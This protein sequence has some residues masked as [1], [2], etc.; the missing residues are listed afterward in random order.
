MA[1]R[2]LTEEEF[3][4][5]SDKDKL[6]Y[7][8]LVRRI[9]GKEELF[10]LAHDVLGYDKI[11]EAVHGK[12]IGLLTK[13]KSR[14]KLFLLPRGS[15][16]SSIAT[17]SYIIWRLLNN[18]NLR[19]LLDSEVLGNSEK[20][21]EQIKTHFRRE[22][23]VNLYG[24][25]IS[26]DKRE[27]SREFTVTNR[28]DHTKKEPSVY[29]A[30]VGTVNVGPH[31]DLII[32]DDLHSEKNVAT[33]DQ[34]HKVINHYRLLLSLLEPEGELIVIG[35][36]WHFLDL[37]SKLIEEEVTRPDTEWIY[38]IEKAI[39]DDGSMF[40]PSRITKEFLEEQRRSQGA[41]LFSCLYQNEPQSGDTQVFRKEDF[42]YW[43]GDDF[44]MQD[45]KR[46][47]LSICIMVD[48]AFSSKES[49]DFTGIVA[50][51]ISASGTIY[52]LDAIRR[53][54]GLQEVF[55]DIIRLGAKFGW[56]RIRTVGIET[57]N[58][59]ELERFFQEQMRKTNRFFNIERLVPDS[60]QSKKDRIEKA[61]QAR[62]SNHSV[63]IKKGM[64][65][66]ED[67]LLRFP[68]GTHDDLI[69]S[70]AYFVRLMNKPSDPKMEE[71]IPEYEPSG[72]F[73][74]SG[75]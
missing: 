1:S 6:E 45:G 40:F 2:P 18:G 58:Y 23:F 43:S 51:G 39:R 73:G 41:Y 68:V 72:L 26:R 71:Y 62:F 69:D 7:L 63:Y 12:L 25:M 48:R 67:E 8:R 10:Y 74:R 30:G 64:F 44:P 15:F 20:F 24:S 46:V 13:D 75:Y 59:E 53:K 22:K 66:L 42:R 36:R 19:I 50:A 60:R 31:Y 29:A 61:L 16:K 3:N 17:V 65:D 21:L 4:K 28:T 9:K 49:A 55:D 57:I 34:I 32:C 11:E 38:Y 70:F 52:V 54:C 56:D 5:L 37:Y 27:T 47:L 35:T 33:E 14:K